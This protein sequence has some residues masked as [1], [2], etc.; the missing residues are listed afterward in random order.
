MRP[1]LQI[2]K[3]NHK[4]KIIEEAKNLL[5][6]LGVEIQNP[7]ALKVLKE[8]GVGLHESGQRITFSEDQIESALNSAPRSFRLYDVS[9]KQSTQFSGK[10]IHFTPGSSAL[11][12]YELE[13]G[14]I[15]KPTRFDYI[16]YV[17][18]ADQLEHIATQS[19]AFIPADIDHSIADMYRLYLSFLYG[20]KAVITGV[21]KESSFEVMLDFQR[22]IRGSDKLLQKKPLTI[23]TCC[24]TS[25]L[26]WGLTASQNLIDCATSGIP[27]EIVSMPLAGFSSPV[28]LNGTLIQH[29]AEILSGLVIHQTVNPGAPVLYGASLTIF[30]MRYQTTP[31]GSIENMLLSCAASEI[32]KNL[33]LP[34]QAYISLSDSRD[35]DTQ[36]G[37]ESGMGACL[38][39]LSGINNIAGPGMMEF[40]NCFSVEKL[41]VDNEIAGMVFRILEGISPREDFPSLPLFEE[42]LHEQHLILSDH[43]IK[44]L[45]EE[46]YNPGQMIN[47]K[48]TV[49]WQEEGEPT[50][51]QRA[52]QQVS[53]LIKKYSP[54]PSTLKY[55]AELNKRLT[56]FIRHQNLHL[57]QIP[58]PD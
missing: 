52:R 55:T 22:I 21:F 25:P 8:S 23:F 28:T 20:H 31:M 49:L 42:L 6:K 5:N 40:E 47:R 39:A 50:F 29:C 24:P 9:G 3:Q 43:T 53:E 32:G 15:R 18:V 58:Y 46:H 45:R 7:Y 57:P 17:K 12:Y 41:I 19:T 54:N 13:T 48:S 11:N 1:I 35:L 16:D 2:L 34:T 14:Q 26:K 4:K 27:V 44:Y 56:E 37:L 36:A 38:A 51:H 33:G 10:K 30:D